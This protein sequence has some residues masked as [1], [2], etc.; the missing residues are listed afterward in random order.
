VLGHQLEFQHDFSKD[1]SA[2]LGLTTRKTSLEGFSTEA[3]LAANRQRLFV[4]GRTLTRQRRF[5]DYD[6]TYQ[7][8]RAE[9]NGRF[10]WPG[11]S[12]G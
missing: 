8:L 6:A 3:E 9:I 2:L 11:C 7:V 5:R 1:W 12:T 4:D 10:R